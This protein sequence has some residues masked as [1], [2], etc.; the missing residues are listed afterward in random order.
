M[1]L[2]DVPSSEGEEG[3]AKLGTMSKVCDFF[4][5][6]LLS[7]NVFHSLKPTDIVA[8]R[9]AIAAN[10]FELIQ[11]IQTQELSSLKW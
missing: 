6:L 2:K 10:N 9:A 8:Y 7:R 3:V 1:S 11:I 5:S 4:W